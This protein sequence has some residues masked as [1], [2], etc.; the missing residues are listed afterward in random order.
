MAQ[1]AV[2]YRVRHGA[3]RHALAADRRVRS[4]RGGG[5]SRADGDASPRL[6]RPGQQ[7]RVSGGTISGCHR[8]QRPTPAG[9]AAGYDACPVVARHAG[10]VLGPVPAGRLPHGLRRYHIAVRLRCHRDPVCVGDAEPSAHGE[11]PGQCT[12]LDHLHLRLDGSSP[13]P[14][15][16]GADA[17]AGSGRHRQHRTRPR[18]RA[19]VF[20][21]LLMT[22]GMLAQLAMGCTRLMGQVNAF[23]THT[24]MHI[25]IEP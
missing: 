15:T 12:P 6:R 3:R 25:R 20:L 19:V 18:P 5:T 2:R 24:N 14:R 21:A 13:V 11:L 16:V 9:R 23:Q 8:A 1:L 4:W 10:R 17:T 7:S 22:A